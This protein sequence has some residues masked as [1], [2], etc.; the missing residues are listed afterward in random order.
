MLNSTC[1]NTSLPPLPGTFESVEH[2]EGS[3]DDLL[4]TEDEVLDL[5]QTVDVSK[6]SGHDK[7]SGS[8]LKATAAS[9]A[10]P[11]TELFNKSISTGCF[12]KMWKRSNLVPI[13]KSGDKGNPAN[14]RPISLLPV[15][16]KLLERH[17]ANVLLQ[18]LTDKQQISASQWGFQNR[19]SIQSL[20]Y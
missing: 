7:I 8:M 14:Y 9:I 19:K 16:S 2:P 15:L 5:L 3:P 11:V 12:P 17:I 20:L 6:A 18:H 1:F 4:C 13:P 10:A